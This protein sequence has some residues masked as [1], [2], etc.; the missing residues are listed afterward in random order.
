MVLCAH[1]GFL[2]SAVIM[3]NPVLLYGSKSAKNLWLY[4]ED[5]HM[6]ALNRSSLNACFV[7]EGSFDDLLKGLK[8]VGLSFFT[9]PSVGAASLIRRVESGN[10]NLQSDTK[11]QY[12][13]WV[14]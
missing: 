14:G 6:A 8:S 3:G 5:A 2:R 9:I 10:F 1:E 7:G 11:L 13:A 4:V 12:Y